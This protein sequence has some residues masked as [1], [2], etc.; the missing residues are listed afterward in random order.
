MVQGAH[1]P[2]FAMSTE[3][4]HFAAPHAAG[5]NGAAGALPQGSG[6]VST[7]SAPAAAPMSSM[8][9]ASDTAMQPPSTLGKRK[10][11]PQDNERLSKRLSL[12]NLGM[13]NLQ[14]CFCF[15]IESFP[16]TL[17]LHLCV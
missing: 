13:C 4:H 17:F 15:R 12:L 8:S 9:S 6:G 14:C 3:G 11:E 2:R 16:P 10:A 5:P 1:S 7:T